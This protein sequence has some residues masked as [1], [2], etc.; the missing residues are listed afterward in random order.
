MV[1]GKGEEGTEDAAI[2]YQNERLKIPTQLTP[3]ESFLY[4]YSRDVTLASLRKISSNNAAAKKKLQ[5]GEVAGLSLL[6]LL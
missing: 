1:G 5:T 3:Q 4:K 2:D 6:S